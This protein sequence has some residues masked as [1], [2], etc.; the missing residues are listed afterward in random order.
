MTD[1]DHA[2]RRAR[3]EQELGALGVDAAFIP[4]SGDLEYL[5]GF[6]RRKASFGNY[7]HVNQWVLGAIL[8]PGREPKF[9]IPQG[10]SAFQLPG[11]V[12]GD[13]VH[14]RN[15]DD[16]Y[17]LFSEAIR[18]YGTLR[19]VGVT[20]RTW[21]AT[22]LNIISATGGAEIVNVEDKIAKMRWV[23]ESVELEVMTR[24]ARICDVVMSEITAEV[25]A[26]VTEAE[27]ASKVDHLMVVHGGRT[28]SFDT[29]VFALGPSST[30]DASIRIAGDPL[31]EKDALCFDFGTVVEGYC[32]DFGRTLHIG[33]PDARYVEAYDVVIASQEAGRKIAVP[34]SSGRE[35][36]LATRKVIDDAGYG[37]WFRHRTGHCIGLDTHELPFISEEDTTP[38]EPNMTFTIEPS[39][40][41]PGTLG[42]RV[43]DI[44]VCSPE[45]GRSLN[46]YSK[47]LVS[48]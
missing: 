24:A 26:G 29:G 44:F 18:S 37:E 27:I 33:E 22:V 5:T 12:D 36:H 32:S 7:E 8:A 30:R 11:G 16:G 42:A 6:P 1:F 35:I 28:P 17:E 20:N 45:G 10:Y 21:A 4:P 38:L 19:R 40:F 3:F 31:R 9:V 46:D 25:H 47:E 43:E 48:V 41:W 23:K 13:V 2:G 15:V 34:G 39:I 14:V